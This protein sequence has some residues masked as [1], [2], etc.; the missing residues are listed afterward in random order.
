MFFYKLS[1]FFFR[2]RVSIYV[3]HIV[4]IISNTHDNNYDL[5][6]IVLSKLNVE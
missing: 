4:L 3:L 6:I 1:N 5:I 2:K